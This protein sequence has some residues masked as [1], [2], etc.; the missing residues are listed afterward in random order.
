MTCVSVNCFE[1]HLPQWGLRDLQYPRVTKLCWR[2]CITGASSA[3]S[4]SHFGSQAYF[5]ISVF[6]EMS[7]NTMLPENHFYRTFR[8]WVMGNVCGCWNFS[9]FKIICELL[10]PFWKIFANGGPNLDCHPSYFWFWVF[11]GSRDQFPGADS[12]LGFD[13]GL[14]GVLDD[15]LDESCG[16][17][18]ED[19]LVLEFD[20][21]PGL[22][23][24]TTFSVLHKIV[25]PCLISRGCL[26]GISVFFA[27]FFKWCVIEYLHRH[28]EIR[29]L[30]VYLCFFACLHL[31][32]GRYQRRRDPGSPQGVYFGWAQILFAQQ[33]IFLGA[34]FRLVS[35]P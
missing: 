5:A 24:G 22:T 27:E 35:S 6:E 18:V 28:D 21:N 4:S 1:I 14:E 32:V 12:S 3:K 9:I 7:T 10:Q 19:E 30:N 29:I 17:D 16:G 8:I 26:Q 31:S 11:G 2:Y 33:R 23:R 13:A 15:A 34:K 25:F 20:D